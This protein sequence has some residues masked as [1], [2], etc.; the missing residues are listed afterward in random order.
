MQPCL[1][2]HLAGGSGPMPLVTYADL[3]AADRAN[4]GVTVAVASL[5]R[6]QDNAR[7][8]P[9]AP[10][11][12]S[13]S[14][15]QTAL[16]SW[17]QASY[18]HGSCGGSDG[19]T[20]ANDPLGAAPTCTSGRTTA[21]G[22]GLGSLMHPGGACNFC[23]GTGEGPTFTVA[24]TV[25]PTGHEP[26]DCNAA[27]PAGVTVVITSHTGQAV[28][29]T[30][31]ADGNFTYSGTL[32]LPY[33]AVVKVGSTTRAMVAAQQSGD[34]NSCHTQAGA[35]GAPGRITVPVT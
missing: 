3:T 35:N 11:P 13:S 9:P 31:N 16:A 28:T 14:A 22:D 30:P 2:C 7:P 25:Y 10:L 23:H 33:T 8:M 19:G 15:D 29:L 18:P 1:S 21:G 4:P 20:P 32:A 6:M 5:A 26:N 12:R 24:G 27:L 17:I 34:C